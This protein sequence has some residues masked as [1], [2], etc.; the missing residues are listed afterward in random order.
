M[1][2]WDFGKAD[3]FYEQVETQVVEILGGGPGAKKGAAGL[4]RVEAITVQGEE[5]CFMI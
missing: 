4:M 3:T 1:S 5:N 2:K